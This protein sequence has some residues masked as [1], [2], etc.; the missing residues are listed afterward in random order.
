MP[1]TNDTRKLPQAFGKE[2]ADYTQ[3]ASLKKKDSN[4]MRDELEKSKDGFLKMLLEGMKHQDPTGKSN[5]NNGDIVQTMAALTMV[6]ASLH[7]SDKL[8]EI[9]QNTKNSDIMKTHGLIGKNISY[10]DSTREFEDKPI[11]FNYQIKRP[12]LVSQNTGVKVNIEILDK[13]GQIVFTGRGKDKEGV[14]SF[15]WNGKNNKGVKMPNEAYTLKVSATTLGNTNA[16]MPVEATTYLTGKVQA[17]EVDNDNI[18]SLII[19]GKRVKTNSIRKVDDVI[20]E[21]DN[22]IAANDY[23]NY[24]GKKAS[25]DLSIIEIKNGKGQV[26]FDN[27]V[28]KPGKIKIDIL[29]KDAKLIKSIELTTPVKRGINDI[30][31]DARKNGILDGEYKCRV[32]VEDK[33]NDDKKVL[34]GNLDNI[35]IIGLDL[36]NKQVLAGDKKYNIKNLMKVTGLSISENSLLTQSGYYVGKTI[37]YE[38][39]DII[40]NDVP[41]TS[42][43][44]IKP[45]EL[46]RKLGEVKLNIYKGDELV[47]SVVKNG[48][49]LYE[50]IPGLH[51]L[52]DNSRLAVNNLINTYNNPIPNYPG[53]DI[54]QKAK[55]DKYIENNF[56]EGTFFKRGQDV[57]SKEVKNKNAGTAEFVWDGSLYNGQQAASG[58]TYRKEIVINSLLLDN[59]DPQNTKFSTTALGLVKETKIENGELKLVLQDD[60]AIDIDVVMQ[61]LN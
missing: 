16:G 25:I 8:D 61:I 38:N 7:Q 36:V 22:K 21:S 40:Y 11:E 50:T 2:Q 43:L 60:K 49:D 29:S 47:A 30:A 56:R 10:D 33:D 58:V 53:L 13:D 55:I 37:Q 45:P 26:A 3:A 41:D 52:D 34:A 32:Y 1:V 57:N 20:D 4:K 17:V 39:N 48:A 5:K 42:I 23:V 35:E 44:N 28:E 51:D 12:E 15:I 18:A 19:N 27:N 14:N 46:G 24:I 54:V 9:A 59:T 31:I 6:D